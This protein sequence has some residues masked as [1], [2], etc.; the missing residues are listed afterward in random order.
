MLWASTSGLSI[1]DIR[2]PLGRGDIL[3]TLS[4]NLAPA[5]WAG[6]LSSYNRQRQGNYSVTRGQ[7]LAILGSPL[8]EVTGF[9]LRS[10]AVNPCAG[11]A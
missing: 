8:R 1:A 7:R 5:S 11:A 6:E 10:I 2:P 9:A 4:R 3:G